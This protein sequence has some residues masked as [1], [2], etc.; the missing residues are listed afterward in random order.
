MISLVPGRVKIATDSGGRIRPFRLLGVQG[1]DDPRSR[2]AER[3]VSSASAT[4]AAA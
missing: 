2:M 3:G 4:K 1:G